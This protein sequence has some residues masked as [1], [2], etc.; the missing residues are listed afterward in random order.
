MSDQP[1][2]VL[3]IEDDYDL[4]SA[5][6]GL[7]V[8]EGFVVVQRHDGETGFEEALNGGYD[9]IVLD[10]MLPRRSGFRVARICARRDCRRPS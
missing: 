6:A 5:V 3:V 7:L 10:I 2:R 4:A 1:L 9:V 8:D